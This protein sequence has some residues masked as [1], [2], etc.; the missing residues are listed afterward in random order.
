[1]RQEW[2]RRG[3]AHGTGVA[4]EH[5]PAIRSERSSKH[6]PQRHV[7]LFRPGLANNYKKKQKT[8]DADDGI[9][10]IRGPVAAS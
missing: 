3:P 9:K 8:L 5:A 6:S 7:G 1:M 10:N 2:H 4:A